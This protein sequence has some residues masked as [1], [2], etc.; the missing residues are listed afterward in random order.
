MAKCSRKTQ[1][2]QPKPQGFVVVAF[3][4]DLEQAKDYEALLK[5]NY[6]PVIL[7]DQ[8]DQ[9]TGGNGIAVGNRRLRRACRVHNHIERPP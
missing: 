6:I 4:E 8:Y 5:I 1:N 3:T 7:N 9:S 2:S